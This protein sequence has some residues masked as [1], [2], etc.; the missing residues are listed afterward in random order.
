MPFL[1]TQKSCPGSRCGPTSFKSGGSG[2]KPSEKFRPG[3]AGRPVKTAAPARRKSAR[4]RLHDGGIV[5]IDGGGDAGMA[6][7]RG[8]TD[9]GQR[10]VH[11]TGIL[12]GRGHV[13]ESAEEKNRRTN[14]NDDRE[15]SNESQQPH[16]ETPCRCRSLLNS[17]PER[18]FPARSLSPRQQC[19]KRPDVG[20]GG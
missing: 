2:R 11:D 1:I 5:E 9:L 3:P 18:K 19:D 8:R 14:D 17:A 4:P 7:D 13:V 20:T 15:R 12:L 6:G 10:P 16:G